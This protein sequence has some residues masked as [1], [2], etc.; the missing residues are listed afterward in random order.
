[1]GESHSSLLAFRPKKINVYALTDE[2]KERNWIVNLQFGRGEIPPNI[3]LSVT[4]NQADKTDAF[5]ADL[6]ASVKALKRLK[7]P[8]LMDIAKLQAGKMIGTHADSGLL[9]KLAPML[10]IK[11]G[12]LPEKMA[13]INELLKELPKDV[14]KELLLKFVSDLYKAK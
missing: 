5:L 11:D 2:L 6:E 14:S 12:Q 3:H 4:H 13:P 10:G 8:K 7:M 1:M 9:E